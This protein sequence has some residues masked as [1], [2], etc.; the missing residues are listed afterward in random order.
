LFPYYEKGTLWDAISSALNSS[1]NTPWP[2]AELICLH[3]FYG[4]CSGVQALHRAGFSH[5]DLKPHNVLLSSDQYASATPVLMDFG[6]CAPLVI[7]IDDRRK[8]L[9]VQDEANRKC[10]PP[11]RAPELFEPE[12]GMTID[13][14]SDVWSLGCIL[15]GFWKLI[16]DNY[17]IYFLSACGFDHQVLHGFRMESF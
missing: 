13:G 6:S 12:L 2:F 7:E 10:S 3:L 4:I 1:P 8:L 5:R 9:D 14:Q 16:Y 17:S 11:Y 15:Y